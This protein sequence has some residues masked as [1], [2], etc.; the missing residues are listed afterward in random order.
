MKR[1]TVFIIAG[2]AALGVM[3]QQ[4]NSRINAARPESAKTVPVP[5]VEADAPPAPRLK[6]STPSK[7]QPIKPAAKPKPV[8]RPVKM[9]A[10]CPCPRAKTHEHTASTHHLRFASSAA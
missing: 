7:A 8:T 3:A 6:A 10:A 4:G 5:E 9:A 1:S 2:L